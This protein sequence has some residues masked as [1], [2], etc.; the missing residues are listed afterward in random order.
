M[1]IKYMDKLKILQINKLYYPVVGGIEKI[2]QQL[3]EG[4]NEKTEMKVLVCSKK[5][6]GGAEQIKGV[7]INRASSLGIFFSMPISFSFI[8]M[9]RKMAKD[10]DVLIFHMPFPLGDFAG[11]LSGFK[12][13]IVV[14][15][16]S[17]V[18]KQQKI[19]MLYE[20]I[21]R[22][23][24][25]RADMI[26]VATQGHIEGSKYLKEY[27]EKCVVVPYGVD[28]KIL[29]NSKKYCSDYNSSREIVFLFVGRFVHYKGCS[30]LLEAFSKVKQGK[31]ILAGDG[32]LRQELMKQAESLEISEVV[33]F[34]INPSDE[35]VM[36][37]YRE[38]DVFVLPSIQRSEA[39]GLVQAEAMAYGKPVINTRL[40]SGVPYVSI[41]GETGLTVEAGN[42][43]KLAEAMVY[44]IENPEIRANMGRAARKR[45]YEVFTEEK[46]IEDTL[47]NIAM[48]GQKVDCNV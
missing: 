7:E 29:E 20:P 12:G 5:G 42:A 31:L 9:L 46:M 48:E 45:A 25:Q 27:R 41:H 17:D 26:I 32:V 40:E 4:L 1:E 21:M 34:V 10:R 23:F 47:R 38:C 24:L 28:G 39:F 36:E 37:L 43:K 19:M 15:W 33:E 35:R 13:K 16:H 2:I 22:K 14:W 3:A 30:V 18:V 8:F 6:K 44:M 11:L